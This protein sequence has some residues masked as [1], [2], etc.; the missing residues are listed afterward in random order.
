M[1]YKEFTVACILRSGDKIW[2]SQ[3]INTENFNGK[4]QC[5][6]GKCEHKENPIDSIIREV[7]EETNLYVSNRLKYLG[8]NYDE[9]ATKICYVY[10][11]DL[12]NDEFPVRTENVM[13]DWVLFSYDEAL[14]KDL[15]PGFSNLIENLRDGKLVWYNIK[16][17]I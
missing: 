2:L 4:W 8:P 12:H 13:T 14:K 5:P 1:E 11:V 17:G 9:S 10:Y 7:K 15:I 6:G 3:R 16:N